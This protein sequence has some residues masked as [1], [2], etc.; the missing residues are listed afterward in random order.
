MSCIGHKKQKS[1]KKSSPDQ[2]T[3]FKNLRKAS[4]DNE[5]AVITISIVTFT[6]SASK[7][8]VCDQCR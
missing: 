4:P 5:V 8:C 2:K 7:R 6:P 1:K 3:R